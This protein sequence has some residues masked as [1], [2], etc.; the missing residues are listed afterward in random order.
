LYRGLRACLDPWQAP[1][2]GGDL[3]R[4]PV[5]TVAITALGTV[6]PGQA[7]RRSGAQVGDWIVATG[8]HGASRAGLELL[9]EPEKQAQVSPDLGQ[10]WILAHRRPRP[11]L[12]VVALLQGWG[13]ERVAGMDSSD[14]LADAVL[15]LCRASGVGARVTDLPLPP[16]LRDWVGLEQACQWALYGGEDFE[17]ILCLPPR[18]AEMLTATLGNSSAIIGEI[19]TELEIYVE[20][21]TG[22][23]ESLSFS[24][25]QHFS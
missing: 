25:F 22:K 4:S 3:C 9:L 6:T 12:D 19:A 7:I 16:G 17:L 1:I 5:A 15:Q 24:G 13:W 2:L 18:Q 14:G 23:R 20:L 8:A 10:R 11:R 21:E